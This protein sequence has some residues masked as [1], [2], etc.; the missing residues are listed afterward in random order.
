M[1][2]TR[3]AFVTWLFISAIAPCL[4]VTAESL[5]AETKQPEPLAD[6]WELIGEAVN[7][8]GWDVW[9]S[10]PI[11]DDEGTT[12]LFCARWPGKIPF[13]Q[14]WRRY[15]EI[16]HYVAP[17]PE[18]PFT[19]VDTIGKGVGKGW[20]AVGYHNPNIRQVGD[21]YAI[22]FI[23]NDGGPRH[24]PNQRI[25]MMTA[26]HLNGP[27]GLVPDE[28]KPLLSP[29]DDT[30]IWCHGSGC[31]VNNPSLLP[32]PNGKFHLYFK[33]QSNRGKGVSM[34]VAIAD[35]LEGPYVIQKDPIT[36]N[37][38]TIEDGYA[39]IWRDHVCLM[40]TDN[41]GI[42]ERGGGLIWVSKDGINFEERPLSGYHHLGGFYLKNHRP[43]NIKHHYTAQTKFERPQLLL[44]KHGEPAYLYCPSGSALDGSNGTN[45]Y[46]LRRR[47]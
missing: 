4:S 5:K 43:K 12:H 8:P 32:L 39:F 37:D 6:Q 41:H 1:L 30:K 2:N 17:R 25:G 35:R 47:K 22:V 10:T 19:Y 15:S 23:S 26:D 7:E 40:T 31:G 38:R 45:A 27:W 20:N 42:L 16:A 9:G 29:P 21:K 13:D 28:T 44:D 24:G 14:A 36:A 11:R 33:A 34:G 3:N 18:G 46:V